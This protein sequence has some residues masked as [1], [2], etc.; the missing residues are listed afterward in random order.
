MKATTKIKLM[1]ISA[2]LTFLSI[3]SLSVSVFINIPGAIKQIGV[4]DKYIADWLSQTNTML[5]VILC[6]NIISF[7][8]FILIC[9][10]YIRN[11][12]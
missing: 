11:K 10:S 9:I 8:S 5:I 3:L 6:M 12:N 1:G 4:G 2:F 7:L